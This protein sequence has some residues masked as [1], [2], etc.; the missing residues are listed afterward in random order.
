METRS[1]FIAI[2]GRPNVGKS[3]LLNAMVGEK[4]AIVS[5]KPQT[6][7]NRIV[8]ILTRGETQLVFIDTPG[9]H[10]PRTKLSEFMVRQVRR[11]VADMDAAV[12]VTEPEKEVTKA[13]R[14][15]LDNIKAMGIP[16]VL[17]INKIDTLKRRED[18]LEK[19]QALSAEYEFEAVVPLSAL[20][21]DGVDIL[22]AE[23]SQLAEEGPHFFDDDDFT[24]QPERVIAGEIIRE[25]ILNNMREEIPHGT[26][27]SVESMKER[28]DKDII[29]ID[30]VIY[31]ERDSHKGMLI[32]KQG[33]MLK[34]IGSQAREEIE[35]FLDAKVNLKLWVKVKEDWRNKEGLIKQFG[36][37]EE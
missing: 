8:G 7:R 17:V 9:M 5:D 12:L 22:L 29:D 10:K 23:L 28:E 30:A 1:A 13:E 27:V 14:E 26:A 21:G 3:S 25:K 6:T 31:C 32:G 20:T 19:M 34:T 11:S 15:L 33:S 36:F 18:M 24:D 4:V 37:T 35:A 16:A 2:V